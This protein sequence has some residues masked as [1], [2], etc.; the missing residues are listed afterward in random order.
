MLLV[1]KAQVDFPHD[2]VTPLSIAAQE[3]HANVVRVLMGSGA[4]TTKENNN[5]A[6][7]LF[8]AARNGHTNVVQQLLEANDPLVDNA[9]KDGT[10]PLLIAIQIGN[11]EVRDCVLV[12]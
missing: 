10:T 5:H 8:L 11:I 1:A 6:S 4:N 7:P 3:G 9:I 12:S 2:N